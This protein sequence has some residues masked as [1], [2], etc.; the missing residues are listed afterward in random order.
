MPES[1]YLI[2]TTT[3][4]K[5]EAEKIAKQLINHQ[6]AACVQISGKITSIYKWKNKIQS[7]T[8]FILNIK[9][10]K[11]KIQAIENKIIQEHSYE[12]P[13]IIAFEIN[14]TTKKY[15]NWAYDLLS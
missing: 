13:E 5:E 12:C 10:I 14:K 9:T 3:A 4:S 8:E 7:E 15:A 2:Q 1:L 11:S 6:L